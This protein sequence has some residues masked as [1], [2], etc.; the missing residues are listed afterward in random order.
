MSGL[1]WGMLAINLLIPLIM[2]LFG[3]WFSRRAPK[4]INDFVGYR[5]T[6]SM[7]NQDTWVFAHHTCGRLWEK[8]GGITLVLT[9]VGMVLLSGRGEDALGIGTVVLCSGQTAVI[10]LSILPVEAALKRT[11]DEN[12]NRR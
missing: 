2:L 5:T 6:R 4:E 11:F 7:K 10:L 9:V 8:L 12:G 1:W 3:I